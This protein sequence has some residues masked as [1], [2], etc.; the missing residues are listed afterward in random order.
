[1]QEIFGKRLRTRIHFTK[2]DRVTVSTLH[3]SVNKFLC[4][5]YRKYGNIG[6]SVKYDIINSTPPPPMALVPNTG[7]GLLIL[8][9]S[10]SHTATHHSR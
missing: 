2:I 9:V 8:E 5:T 3:N 10:I 7:R 6:V 4:R 1:M